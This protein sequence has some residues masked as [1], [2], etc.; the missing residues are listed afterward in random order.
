MR[1]FLLITSLAGLVACTPQ[2]PDSG[3]PVD[4]AI[5]PLSGGSL[6]A[7]ADMSAGM[8]GASTGSEVGG[9]AGGETGGETGA[10]TSSTVP[11]TASSTVPPT[12]GSAD[13]SNEQDFGAVSGRETIESDAARI[14]ANRDLY[15]VVEATDLPDRPGNSLSKVVEY[16]LATT[17]PVGQPLYRRS[18]LFSEDRFNRNCVKYASPDLAQ[19]DFLSRGGPRRDSKGLDPDGDGFACYWTPEPYRQARAATAERPAPVISTE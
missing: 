9:E 3:A 5:G 12:T 2:I 7:A 10:A 18:G 16:A 14:A 13:I 6:G 1:N 11:N 8:A 17:N 19:E 15:Q 4:A